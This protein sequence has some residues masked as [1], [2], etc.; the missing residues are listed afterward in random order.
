[1]TSIFS[2]LVTLAAIIF[3]VFRIIITVLSSMGMD[4]AIVP[5][6]MTFE[7]IVL[8]ITL[9]SFI[10]IIKRNIFGALLYF[11]AYGLYFGTYIYDNLANN[12]ENVNFLSLGVSIIGIVIATFTLLDILINKN[13]S[14]G[15]G[16]KKT[17]WFYKGEQYDRKKD[18]RADEN[19][20]K[21]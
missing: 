15:S 13:R 6:N 1:M 19:Q 21:F 5:F 14:V 17:D 20:Y 16:D 3:W 2:Y 7:I 8:F 10:F 18:E 12:Q 11:V 4:F 9:F